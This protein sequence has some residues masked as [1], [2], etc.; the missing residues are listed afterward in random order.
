M[1]MTPY[2]NH[3]VITRHRASRR[4]A[5]AESAVVGRLR[6]ELRKGRPGA[7]ARLHPRVFDTT[8]SAIPGG[9]S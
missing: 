8:F 3:C 5:L 4:A 1:E 2:K 7:A 6:T 9:H